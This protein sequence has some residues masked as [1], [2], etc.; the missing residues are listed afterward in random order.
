MKLKAS[1]TLGDK[2]SFS[3]PRVD[4]TK[5]DYKLYSKAS[6]AGLDASSKGAN[7]EKS[8]NESFNLDQI[9]KINPVS[10]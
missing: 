6:E 1:K 10:S 2:T 3:M 9:K 8:L 5:T 4:H 7:A